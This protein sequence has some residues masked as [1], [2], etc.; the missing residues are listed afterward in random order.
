MNDRAM[1]LPQRQRLPHGIPVWA[2]HEA[3]LFVTICCATRGANQLCHDPVATPIWESIE[4]RQRRGDWFVHLWLLMPDHLHALVSFPAERDPVRVIANWKEI[5]A[6]KAGVHW[7]RD[8]FDH[9]L[10]S[11]ESLQQ[12]AGYIRQ[13]PVRKGLVSQAED[14]K[15]VWNP[16]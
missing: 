5:M 3:I 9:R 6:K 16:N 11:G 13:N 1:N 10:R 12:K 2:R 15:F 8:F 14:W 7:Q 4:W